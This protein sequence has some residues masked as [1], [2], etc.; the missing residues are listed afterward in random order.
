MKNTLLKFHFGA[1]F[2]VIIDLILN[3]KFDFGLT[4]YLALGMKILVFLS[5]MALFIYYLIQKRWHFYFS[6]YPAYT[7]IVTLGILTQNMLTI[8]LVWPIMWYSPIK[9]E[10]DITMIQNPGFMSNAYNVYFT[11]TKAMIFE[12]THIANLPFYINRDSLRIFKSK[13]IIYLKFP[14][15]SLNAEKEDPVTGDTVVAYSQTANLKL[16]WANDLR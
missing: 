12:K 13:G 16:M 14:K 2:V 9:K 11:E 6:W 3:W 1:L 15:Q 10:G 7:I 8:I 5:G 4:N